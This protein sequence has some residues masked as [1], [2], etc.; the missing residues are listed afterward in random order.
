VKPEGGELP[1]VAPAA[2]AEEPIPADEQA[3]AETQ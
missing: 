2:P 1:E 3:Q